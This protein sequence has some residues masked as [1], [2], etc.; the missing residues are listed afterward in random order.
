MTTLSRDHSRWLKSLW[1]VRECLNEG[2]VI[3][4]TRR[5]DEDTRDV[6]FMQMVV[7]VDVCLLD[8]CL[9]WQLK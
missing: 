1:Q 4:A 3:T 8:Y 6:E 9:H 2:T 5:L 7:S